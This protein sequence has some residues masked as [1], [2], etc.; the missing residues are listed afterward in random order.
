MFWYKCSIITENKMPGLKPFANDK[1]LFTSSA[2]C[3][4][5]VVDL[6]YV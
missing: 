6:G 4:G 1:I 2:V 3:S 5:S